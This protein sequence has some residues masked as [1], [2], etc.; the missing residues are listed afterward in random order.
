MFSPGTALT[1]A[2]AGEPEAGVAEGGPEVQVYEPGAEG[3]T[4]ALPSAGRGSHGSPRRIVWISVVSD[5]TN[6][7]SYV[8]RV[9]RIR[10]DN[11]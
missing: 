6:D 3:A 9:V 4:A 11:F 8:V 1:A 5:R 10:P 2:S 7:L